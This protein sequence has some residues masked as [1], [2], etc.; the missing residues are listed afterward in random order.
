[1]SERIVEKPEHFRRAQ[2]RAREERLQ[3]DLESEMTAH[4][5]LARHY[6]ECLNELAEAEA[7]AERALK[8]LRRMKAKA[9]RLRKMVF[10]CMAAFV[11]TVIAVLLL[12]YF[13]MMVITT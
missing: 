4:R 7:T 6:G 1:M 12:L 13:D 2:E 9:R 10:V 8:A 3:S 5:Q 11:T